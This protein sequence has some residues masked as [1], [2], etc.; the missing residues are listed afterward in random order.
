[1]K[2]MILMISI[3]LVTVLAA[4]GVAE[5]PILTDALPPSIQ[6]ETVTESVSETEVPQTVTEDINQPTIQAEPTPIPD[7]ISIAVQNLQTPWEIVFLPDGRMLITERPG[8]LTLIDSEIV[9]LPIM[10]VFE[11]SESGLLGLTLHPDFEENQWLYLYLTYEANNGLLNRVERY[12]FDG[13]TLTDKLIIID[14]IPGSNNHDGGRIEFGPDGLLYITTGDAGNSSS[15]QDKNSLAGKILRLHDDGS[16]P[17]DNPFGSAVF[18]YGHRNPQGLAWDD[19]GRLWSTEHGPSGLGSGYDELNLIEPG[20]NYGWPEIQGDQ[21]RE[22]M[23]SPRLQS[24]GNETWAPGDLE[25]VDGTVYFVGL[26]GSTLYS[27]PLDDIR[28]ETIQ[29]HFANEFGRLRALRLGPDGLLYMGT[30]NTDGRGSIR[31]GDDK[32][33]KIDPNQLPG[34]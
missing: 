15:A 27:V 29:R 5:T 28:S 8:T 2:K 32:I 18:S 14:Q 9:Q 7:A 25:I 16:I 12:Q 17:Q 21:T 31:D 6:V 13:T 26:R 24:G 30:S 19:Q 4:C 1:M 3:L 33:F 11:R 20:G 10:D 23:I 34:Q 22:G